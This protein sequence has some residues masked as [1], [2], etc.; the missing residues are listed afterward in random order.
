MSNLAVVESKRQV[1]TDAAQVMSFL[2]PWSI[3]RSRAQLAMYPLHPIVVA[4]S[5]S[6]GVPYRENLALTIPVVHPVDGHA[7]V[8]LYDVQHP[9]QVRGFVRKNERCRAVR[10][11]RNDFYRMRSAQSCMVKMHDRWN[12]FRVAA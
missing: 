10:K 12:E 4:G 5:R 2:E 8:I 7:G 11:M 3:R 6:P 1:D 9:G